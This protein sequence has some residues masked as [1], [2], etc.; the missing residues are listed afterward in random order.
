[1]GNSCQNLASYCFWVRTGNNRIDGNVRA[2]SAHTSGGK[3]GTRAGLVDGGTV[4]TMVGEWPSMAWDRTPGQCR[5]ET[6]VEASG[7]KR[8]RLGGALTWRTVVIVTGAVG[9]DGDNEHD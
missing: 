1:M 8:L 2:R 3:S 4:K 6:E 7:S 5:C 9:S